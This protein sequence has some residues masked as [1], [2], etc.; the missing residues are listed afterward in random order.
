MKSAVEQTNFI[1]LILYLNNLIFSSR[2]TFSKDIS[3][4]YLFKLKNKAPFQ[5]QTKDFNIWTT[6]SK[7]APLRTILLVTTFGALLHKFHW[8]HLYLK[9]FVPNEFEIKSTLQLEYFQHWDEF[10]TP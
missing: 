4:L 9:F 3:G 5:F 7:K 6:V 10:F 8:Q 1:Y 2:N